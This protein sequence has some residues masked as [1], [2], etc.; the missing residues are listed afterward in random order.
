MRN[1]KVV[2]IKDFSN[3]NDKNEG[4]KVKRLYNYLP[5]PLANALELKTMSRAELSGALFSLLWNFPKDNLL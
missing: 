3:F 1:K 2:E 5:T 4:V